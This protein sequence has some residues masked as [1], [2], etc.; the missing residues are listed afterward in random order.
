MKKTF[1]VDGKKYE[2]Q[3]AD[4][5][6][7][8]GDYLA[9]KA[10]GWINTRLGESVNPNGADTNGKTWPAVDD[11]FGKHL[12]TEHPKYVLLV[13][14]NDGIYR[15]GEDIMIQSRH[16]GRLSFGIN[17]NMT[18]DNDGFWLVEFDQGDHLE[19][20]V[21]I[22]VQNYTNDIGHIEKAV[23]QYS[24]F[25]EVHSTKL[26]KLNVTVH[27]SKIPLEPGDFKDTILYGFFPNIPKQFKEAMSSEGIDLSEYHYIIRLYMDPSGS[28]FPPI[29]SGYPGVTWDVGASADF[30]PP[31]TSIRLEA[32]N[33]DNSGHSTGGYK[34]PLENVLIHEY[35][36][37]V[38]F[39]FK[40]KGI[41]DFGHSD[42]KLGTLGP[43]HLKY[44]PYITLTTPP[45]KIAEEGE[46]ENKDYYS[47]ILAKMNSL[48]KTTPPYHLFHG[49][50]GSLEY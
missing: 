17:D 29:P 37:G 2:L 40:T 13:G 1:R 23:K 44:K 32:T 9:I 21:L 45:D 15:G 50:F 31:Q 5:Y 28:L 39:M 38:D 18:S 16:K 30:H 7:Y 22:V 19:H 3:D 41:I 20:K 36:H 10:N 26:L 48:T 8:E 27:D 11:A 34:A 25:V 4:S 33:F 24:D 49:E 42:N 35:L 46:R 47:R 43:N 14:I 6:V 12:T